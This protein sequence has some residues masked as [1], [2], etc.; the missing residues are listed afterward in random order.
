MTTRPPVIVLAPGTTVYHGTK[1]ESNEDLRLM[2]FVDA[3]YLDHPTHGQRKI[4]ALLIRDGIV[5]SIGRGQIQRLRDKM[6][7]R[8]IYRGPRT[9]LPGSG[10]MIRPYL[11][12]KLEVSR[13]NQG[14]ARIF[15]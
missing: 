2:H 13:S 10:A 14:R 12:R 5:E 8:T 4:R 1:A 6:S 3:L 15:L 9:T 11:L 7:L